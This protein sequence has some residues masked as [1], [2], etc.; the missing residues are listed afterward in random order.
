MNDQRLAIIDPSAGIAGDMLLAALVDA[1]APET[2]LRSLP[3]RLGLEGVSVQLERVTRCG[4]SCTR[5]RVTL[6]E[7]GVEHP[8]PD[9]GDLPLE[10]V[11]DHLRP[12]QHHSPLEAHVHTGGA[13]GHRHLRDLLAIV[14]GAPLT[15][16]VRDRAVEALRLLCAEEARVHG[17]PIDEVALHEVGAVDA[18]VDIVGCIEGFEQLGVATIATMPLAFGSGWVRTAH[19]V[20]SIPAPVT[21]RLAEGLVI[22]P[23][24]PVTGEATTPTGAVLLRVLVNSPVP[25]RWRVTCTAWGAGTRDSATHPNAVRLIL[26]ESSVEAGQVVTLSTDVDDMSPEYLDPLR[27]A[28]M[29]SGAID[30]QIWSTLMKKGRPGFRIEVIC[31]PGTAEDVTEALFLHSTTLGLRRTVHDR[32][33]LRRSDLQV[34]AGNG[35]EVAVK[36]VHTAAGIRAKAE[37]DDVKRVAEQTG[38]PAFEI[39][40]EI[41]AAARSMVL[42]SV[43]DT[44]RSS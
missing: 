42:T 4:I 18:I 21:A 5:V 29:N 24:G 43:Q 25:P 3:G 35:Q 17:V 40:R 12:H 38:R 32:I 20:M 39:A 13:A 36:V 19:G 28:L 23:N 6:P 2:W 44:S 15:P 22:G 11:G 8:N 41:E 7:G 14:D 33:T 1:G 26:A 37:F 30:V 16:W 34:S 9:Y 31:S 10:A 27:V